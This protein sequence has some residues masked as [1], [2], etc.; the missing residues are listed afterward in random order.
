[1]GDP[2]PAAPGVRQVDPGRGRERSSA[3]RVLAFLLDAAR[4]GVFLKASASKPVCSGPEQSV[5][6]E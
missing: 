1:M 3:S 6:K 4:S 5:V 2:V